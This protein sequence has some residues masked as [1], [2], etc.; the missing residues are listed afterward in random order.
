MWK[1]FVV[2]TV[3]ITK[4]NFL[5]CQESLSRGGKTTKTF[6]TSNLRK[7]LARSHAA[8][9]ASLVEEESIAQGQPTISTV[10]E[11]KT[12]YP[13][14]HPRAR[15]L[16]RIIGELIAVDNE[17]FNIVNRIGFKR[18]MAA[19]EPR[20][21]IPSDKYFSDTLIPDMYEKVKGKLLTIVENCS[22]VS[23]TTDLWSSSSQDSYL[24]LTCHFV[25]ADFK[26]VQ[27]CLHAVSFDDSHTGAQIASTLINCLQAWGIF[28]ALHVVVRDNGSNFVA[29]LRDNNIPNIPCLAHT[30]QLVVHD[31]CLAQPSVTSLTAKARK[32]VGYY[33]RSNLA[34]KALTRIQ[35][36]LNCPVHRLIQ[37]EPTRWN[38]TY[39]MLDRLLEQRQAITAANVEL[40][41]PVELRSADWMLGEKVVKIL[42]V[43][44]E[45]TRE[46]SGSNATSAIVIPV[47]N[48]ILRYLES[49][50]SEDDMGIR[51]MKREMLQSLNS[52]YSHVETNKFYCLSTILD[53]RFKLRV[54]S[55][56]TTAALAKQMLISEYEQFQV[57]QASNAT[58]ADTDPPAAKRSPQSTSQESSSVL[59]TLCND[60]IGEKS[61]YESS[62]D[63]VEY[64][65]DSYIKEQNQSRASDPLSYWKERE[66]TWPILA[67]I[68]RRYLSAPPSSVAS[69][70]LFSSAGQISTAKR[71]RL[72]PVNVERL[73][74]LHENL[75]LLNF[76][77]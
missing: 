24:S 5:H 67:S 74:F 42:K 55:S 1:H 57:S 76:D 35:E 11:K 43:F 47:V 37:D 58:N 9:H 25:T 51:R 59:W 18:L 30:L 65:V 60:I 17:A 64:V 72:A 39:Y 40:D 46:A 2:N 73:L 41:V 54:F 63:S 3:D 8:E 33:R 29:G 4:A 68:G 16:T 53:P 26:R 61:D 36:Q 31:G 66:C 23:I 45:A 34:C 10:I 27:A 56:S 49:G 69:E 14:D 77:Y 15:Q 50:I 52:R 7:H 6:G 44:E 21:T 32:L 13:F 48:S 62:T 20:Y 28:D 70:R 12:P 22:H 19:V 71:N 38:T 75:R